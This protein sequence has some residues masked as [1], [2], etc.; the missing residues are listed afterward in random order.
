MFERDALYARLN[1]NLNGSTDIFV[2]VG[3]ALVFPNSILRMTEQEAGGAH[4]L[5]VESLRDL[6]SFSR[7]SA[8][9]VKK[10]FFDDRLAPEVFR[11]ITSFKADLPDAGWILAYRD[12]AV[13]RH[14][15]GERGQKPALADVLLLPM[16][17]PI[18]PWSAMLRLVLAGQLLAAG[19]LISPMPAGDVPPMHDAAGTAEPEPEGDAAMDA[20]A[21]SAKVLSRAEG[22]GDAA[23]PH[24]TPREEE[25]LALVSQGGRNKTIAHKMSLSEH[26]VKLHL[27]NAIT[28][29]GARNRTEAANW[30][31]SRHWGDGR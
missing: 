31:L 25:V 17:L 7:T 16:M 12:P 26:T 22:A 1:N 29:I 20:P 9:P 4:A 2:F 13:A 23:D 5:R 3:S 14:L 11:K 6:L 24:L 19:D 21:M 18:C 10:V 8:Q 15:L 27:H 28:K 30:Y